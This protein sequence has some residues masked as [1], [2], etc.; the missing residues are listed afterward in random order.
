MHI[1]DG[2]LSVPI[3]AGGAI[4]SLAGIFFGLKR[5]K[6]EDI[7]KVAVLSSVFFTVSLI[8]VPVGPSCVHPGMNGLI[9]LILGWTSFPSIFVALVVQSVVLQFGG[10]TAI[11][12]NTC[13]SA[14]PAV[15]LHYTLRRFINSSRT[16]PFL[17]GFLFGFLGPLLCAAIVSFALIL[18]DRNFYPLISVIFMMH[19]PISAIEG[20]ISGFAVVYLK[21]VDPRILEWQ[22]SNPR[23]GSTL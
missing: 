23:C 13:A 19:L 7:P 17:G 14:L 15:L 5:V 3:L 12:V 11:G 10:V 16:T 9:G 18:S 4:G 21:K 20:I 6:T 1:Q 2:V 8:H 22:R